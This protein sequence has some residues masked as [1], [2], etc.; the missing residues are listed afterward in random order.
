MSGLLS[1]ITP[2][3][4]GALP[5]LSDATRSILGQQ[6]PGGWS[7]EWLVQHDGGTV[8]ELRRALGGDGDDPRLSL[9]AN[10][11]GGPAV[12]RNLA[13]ARVRGSLVKVLDADDQLTP[14]VLRRDIDVLSRDDGV[15]WTTSRAV[16]VLPDGR[17]VGFEDD[18][19]PGRLPVGAVLAYW[20]THDFRP[21]VHPA[22]L[23][24]ETALVDLLGGWMAL[25]SS[26]DTGLLLA[27]DAVS[28]GYFTAEVGLRYRTGP[29][30][31]TASPGHRD[32]VERRARAALIGRRARHLRAA[33][34][35][36]E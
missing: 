36:R 35:R 26:E 20:E 34:V 14:G 21:L 11:R 24:A 9:G 7:L 6:L 31:L 12:A 4:P 5:H 29:G 22:T 25:P 15:R 16:D 18:P 1:V 33:A 17:I 10:R 13:L 28:G 23:C 3:G 19:A 2:V 8:D 27:L 32:P 30:Q